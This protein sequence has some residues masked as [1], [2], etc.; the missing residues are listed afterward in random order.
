MKVSKKDVQASF[1]GA[2]ASYDQAAVVQNEILERLLERLDILHNGG[3][4]LLDLGSGTG[5]AA[6]RLAA[7]ADLQDYVAVD[8]SEKMLA[9]A[10]N[11]LGKYKCVCGDAE[12][13]PFAD[14]S[15][16]TVISAST[17]Q[18]CNDVGLAFSEVLRTLKTGGLFL[19]STF[20]PDTLSEIKACFDNIDPNPHVNSFVDMHELGDL[21]A[22]VGFADIVMEREIITLE[23][24]DPMQLLRDLQATGATNRIV[25]RSRGLLGKQRLNKFLQEYQ[26]FQ[27][28][29]G[30]YPATYE[31]IYGHGFRPDTVN[32]PVQGWQPVKFF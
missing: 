3:M 15:F 4:P 19:F 24:R 2:A 6:R 28:A 18:W 9:Y 31:V 30:L 5:L 14:N 26:R 20:G 1:S 7:S 27:S 12:S 11:I 13:L 23:Y 32:N 29:N 10:G 16:A 22:V 8:I 21:L 25:D 17:L